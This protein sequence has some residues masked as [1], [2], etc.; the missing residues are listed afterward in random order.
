MSPSERPPMPPPDPDEV[1]IDVDPDDAPATLLEVSEYLGDF[2]SIEA[3]LRAMLDPEIAP[4][5][6]WLLDCLDMGRVL[7]RFESD[8]SR[9]HIEQGQVFRTRRTIA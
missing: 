9:L 8:G 2:A 5:V 6:A 4:G 3:Y 7:A 1:D